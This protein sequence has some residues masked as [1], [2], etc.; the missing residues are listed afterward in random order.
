MDSSPSS[1]LPLPCSENTV[2][3]PTMSPVRSSSHNLSRLGSAAKAKPKARARASSTTSSTFTREEL[4]TAILETVRRE[5][6]QS[7]T[8]EEMAMM[9]QDRIQNFDDHYM[10]EHQ[11]DLGGVLQGS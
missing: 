8:P 7:S 6:A 9:E 10:E 2:H 4:M 5:V 1:P 3:L 11:E